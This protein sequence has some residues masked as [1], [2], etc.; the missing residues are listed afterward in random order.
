[1]HEYWRFLKRVLAG[2]NAKSQPLGQASVTSPTTTSKQG[3]RRFSWR[4][5]LRLLG[6]VLSTLWLVMHHVSQI[7]AGFRISIESTVRIAIQGAIAI[8]VMLYCL[9]GWW[10]YA[11][12]LPF[13]LC[14]LWSLGYF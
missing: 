11:L 12:G 4:R 6:T 9:R 14:V 7:D 2:D 3:Y 1:M 5:S 10:R 13:A 8:V